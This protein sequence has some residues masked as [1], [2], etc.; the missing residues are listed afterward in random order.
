ME[1]KWK[2]AN[3]EEFIQKAK[4]IAKDRV[5]NSYLLRYAYGID[6]SCYRYI[7]QVVV[8]VANETEVIELIH[9]AKKCKTP[10]TFKAAGSSLS[11]QCCSDS[12]LIIANDGWKDYKIL[13]N[14]D[15]I[16]LQCG[17]IGSDANK[18]LQPYGKKIGPDP[19]TI[20]TALIGGILNNNA[21]GMCCGV[22]QN[23]YQTIDSLR[24]ILM[25][26]T[27]L[28]T[29]DEVSFSK[30]LN[31][32]KDLVNGL[33][34]IRNEIYKD[35]ELKK[36]I[37]KKFKIKNTTGYSINS[38]VDFSD[39]RD[40]INH[41]FI[42]SEGT[43]GFVSE[44]T[45]NCVDDPKFKGCALMFFETL[46]DASRA[47]VAINP[48]DKKEVVAA[49]MMDY[50]CLKSVANLSNVPEFLKNVKEGATCLLLQTQSSDEKIVDRNLKVIKQTLKDIPVCMPTLISKDPN[51]YNSWWAIRKGILPIAAGA[52]KSKSVVIV[53]D[54]CFE[55]DKFCD[56]VIMLKN[57]F[58][59]YGFEN[60]GVI[61][62][63][64]LSGNL[65]F[66]ITPDLSDKNEYENFSNL[67]K[68]MAYETANM[69]GSIKAEHGTG[70][71]VAP[72][73][74]VEWGKKAYEIN[75]KVK[76]LFDKEFLLNPDVIITDDPQIYKKNMKVM[77]QIDDL[78]N[79]CMECGAC[80]RN[81]PSKNIT[82][83]PRQRIGV[84]REQQRAL[85]DGDIKLSDELK[86]GFEYY[87]AE[88]CA[89]CS[90]CEDLCP[91]SIDTAKIALSLR[92]AASDKTLNLANKIYNNID[93]TVKIAKFALKTDELASKVIGEKNISKITSAI[94]SKIPMF[95]YA[96]SVMPRANTYELKSQ[97]SSQNQT[98]VVYFTTCINRG[99]APNKKMRDTR[100]LQEVFES[101]C[102]KANV[103][104]IYPQ[105][106]DRLCCGMGFVNYD[107][108]QKQ[109][110]DKFLDILLKASNG[111]KY[112]IVIDHS[113]C[114]Y[115]TLKMA[116]KQNSSLNI[117]DIS[118]FLYKI[119]SNLDIK[120]IDE[121]IIVH[122]Q[123][124]LKKSGKSDYIEKLAKMCSN[125]V[126]DIES[127]ACC[128]FAGDKGFFTPELNLS[129]TKNLSK[130]IK[131]KAATIG[132]S[133]SSSCE[134]GLN[135]Q[136]DIS[137][138]S[139][140]YLLDRC[141]SKKH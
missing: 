29:S 57:L 2:E 73:V 21:S 104:V 124:E 48:L 46:E 26:G 24:V 121:T 25:D 75:K 66:V 13:K 123:C 10:I 84:L 82:L 100:A 27:L 44:V 128:G 98:S 108:I 59:R 134:I 55:I 109:N 129:A 125:S 87:G 63:H 117:L 99:F 7:P 15:K 72:F 105:D 137:F 113:A 106:L 19:A 45:Y 81:C 61:F 12:V 102:K 56:G 64:A 70:R 93:K 49:E 131:F 111:G 91:L 95:P 136:S 1:L 126:F 89:A 4:K 71:M 119:S 60:N 88:T 62:G 101:L 79:L 50:A 112:D 67:V 110:Q 30:F 127:F 28:D 115:H 11:G 139:I 32:H 58:K 43:L 5:F 77:S 17:V 38:F 22:Y 8:K 36:L 47:V 103:N 16:T 9:L 107:S 116:A 86:K 39:I 85:E 65:H 120:K 41:I 80:E 135:S 53:E 133:S 34:D 3:Y 83:T 97:I 51:E 92:K 23:S 37:E 141:S 14:A 114:F 69:G 33:L 132:V 138:Q 35:D 31:T 90:M 52:R 42:G 96:P 40:I 20:A 76:E 140:A 68:D 122:K 18:Y 130:E 6:A 94:H 54:V 118:E 78:F 74:E